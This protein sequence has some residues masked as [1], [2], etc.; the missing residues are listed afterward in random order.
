MCFFDGQGSLTLIANEQVVVRQRYTVQGDE[1]VFSN[2]AGA[3]AAPG[4]EE[5]GRYR[6]RFEEDMLLFTLL[7][8]HFAGRIGA[9]SYTWVRMEDPP[10]KP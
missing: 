1:I 7:E 8:D 5:P 9:L 4:E 6:W 3:P 10:V 2:E